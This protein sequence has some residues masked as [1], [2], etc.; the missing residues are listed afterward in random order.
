M[1]GKKKGSR[2]SLMELEE[3]T[4]D[5]EFDSFPIGLGC[6]LDMFREKD[7]V[8]EMIESLPQVY[9]TELSVSFLLVRGV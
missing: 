8:I 3:A 6:A 9:T 7:E 5:E 2:Q 1:S 4:L